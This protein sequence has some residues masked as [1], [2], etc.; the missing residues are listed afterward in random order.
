MVAKPTSSSSYLLTERPSPGL[1]RDALLNRQ[2]RYEV[3]AQQI[4][5]EVEAVEKA[6]EERALRK[7]LIEFKMT[8]A[9]KRQSMR[10]LQEAE[11]ILKEDQEKREMESSLEDFEMAMTARRQQQKIY[12]QRALYFAEVIARMDAN[13]PLLQDEKYR[14][15]L[16]V[17]CDSDDMVVHERKRLE[18]TKR[19]ILNDWY[20]LQSIFTEIYNHE[21]SSE[22]DELEDVE[23]L[24]FRR[25]AKPLSVSVKE[26]SAQLQMDPE[27][28]EGD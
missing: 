2:Q 3:W 5:R 22:E 8:K 18:K 4:G 17:L 12:E 11:R 24:T 10:V 15:Y 7:S 19:D 14:E 26:V 28:E 16:Y 21:Q 23:V 1:S 9:E 6:K 27:S 25:G 13:C 20:A